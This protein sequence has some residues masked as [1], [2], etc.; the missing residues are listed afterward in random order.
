M[1]ELLNQSKAQRLCIYLGES[2]RWRG[3]PLYAA[4]LET[5]RA[6]DISGATVLRGVGGFGA[7]SVIHSASIEV[8]STDL[9]IVVEVVDTPEKIAVALEAVTPMVRE[10]LVT[11]EDV[12][13]VRHTHRYLNPLPADRLAGEVMSREVIALGPTQLVQE[14]W[15]AMLDHRLKALPVVD[16]QGKVVGI[17]TDEDLLARAGIEERLSVAVRMEPEEIN[18][19]LHRLAESPL[20]VAAVMTRPVI[21]AHVGEHLGAVV[22]RMVKSGLKRLP[23]VDEQ[24]H[25]VG[26]LSRLDVLQLVANTPQESLPPQ[27]VAGAVRTAGEI[28]ASGVPLV[29]QADGLVT[30]VE[31]FAQAGTHRLIVV[32]EHGKAVGLISDADVVARIQP[33]RRGGILAALRRSERVPAGDETAGDLMSPGPLTAP[34]ALSVVEA[35]RRMMAEGRKWMVVVDAEGRPLGLVDRQILLQALSAP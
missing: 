16:R 4:L 30:L 10:G 9:P 28:M 1:P 21:T 27:P 13:I 15:K 23:V 22:A 35:I 2:D 18:R 29:R 14:A 33:A 25:L 32:D 5:L 11:V 20:H 3:R 19:Q 34:P 12:R 7:H 8:L 24:E 31:R 6:M 26:M 17:L